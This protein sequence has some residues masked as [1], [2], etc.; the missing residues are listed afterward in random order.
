MNP[1]ESQ[2]ISKDAKDARSFTGKGATE[3]ILV[4]GK[5]DIQMPKKLD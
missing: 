1:Q 4:L 5:P 2:L 3:S